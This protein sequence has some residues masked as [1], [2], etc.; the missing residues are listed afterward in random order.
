VSDATPIVADVAAASTEPDVQR[1]RSTVH[2]V[3][4]H[5]VFVTKYRRPVLTGKMLTDCDH[6]VAELWLSLG[7]ELREFNARDRSRPLAR[8][9]P[10]QPRGYRYWSNRLT[11]V[12]SRRLRQRYP[13][14]VRKYPWGKHFCSPPYFA[15]SCRGAP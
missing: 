12:S 1:G 7:A 3:H 14:Q 13:K 4:A 15:A 11:G 6:L 8:A 9:K 10:T 5:L 2:T